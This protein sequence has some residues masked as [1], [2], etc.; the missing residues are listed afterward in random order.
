MIV[1]VLLENTL[2]NELC[3]HKH[4]LSLHIQ[5]ET[6]HI[7]FDVGPDDTFIHNAE[8][9][10]I[11]LKKVD[12]VIIS[13]GHADHGGGLK[14]FLEM[15]D[16]ANIYIHQDAF[17]EH[18][19]KLLK[20]FKLSVGLD[21]SLENH[22]QV[23][24]TGNHLDIDDTLMIFSEVSIDAP[25]PQGNGSLYKRTHTGESHDDFTHEQ[26]LLITENQQTVLFMGCC[27]RGVTNILKVADAVA[28]K[29]IEIAIGGFH[30]Y[31][32]L[33]KKTDD[34][35]LKTISQAISQRQTKF[36]TGH[37]TGS[38]AMQALKKEFNE[39]IES[40]ATGKCIDI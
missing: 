38:E 26:H 17:D 13:H 27:H 23:I 5:T 31:N 29:P 11:D 37:C 9:L 8:K 33:N 7:L 30:L 22:Q 25:V 20:I 40:L 14:S 10:N 36:Y 4:G 6:H 35:L 32:P 39:Q 2:E 21:K 16:H 12:T 34:A 19:A 15:N 3:Q 28:K 1:T 24:L 18:Y